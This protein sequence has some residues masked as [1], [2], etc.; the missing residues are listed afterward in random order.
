MQTKVIKLDSTKIDSAK[1]TEAAQLVD[2]GGLAAF[3]T[4]T[5]YGIACRVK[6]D[7]LIKLDN[8]KGRGPEK[9]YTLHIGRKSDVEKYLPTVRLKAQKLIKNAWP[10]PLKMNASYGMHYMILWN[11]PDLFCQYRS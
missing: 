9:Y 3:P 7:S 2:A 6:T 1:I 11:H 8:L 4:E 5:V 10:G